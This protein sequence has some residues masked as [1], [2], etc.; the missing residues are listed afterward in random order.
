MLPRK[1]KNQ[2]HTCAPHHTILSVSLGLPVLVLIHI[3][4]WSCIQFTAA[5][6][7]QEDWS[8]ANQTWA[9]ISVSKSSKCVFWRSIV[10]SLSTRDVP[11]SSGPA[12]QDNWFSF[13]WLLLWR[14]LPLLSGSNT[15]LK[16]GFSVLSLENQRHVVGNVTVQKCWYSRW[17]SETQASDTPWTC[18][19]LSTWLSLYG[20]WFWDRYLSLHS[21]VLQRRVA[22][23]KHIALFLLNTRMN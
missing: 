22:S 2:E 14:I 20:Q 21:T 3:F 11:F 12:C 4:F 10:I 19:S 18:C 13:G 5:R 6:L 9:T 7:S 23:H 16:E 15:Y 8:C 1:P 17:A